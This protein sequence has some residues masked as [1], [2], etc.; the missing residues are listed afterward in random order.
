MT[1]Q[2]VSHYRVLEKLGEGAMGVVYKAEDT[3]L[4][5]TVA[6]K[7][8]S[9]RAMAD[10][11]LSAR[12]L[13]EA[14]AAA[15][16]DHPNICRVYG[17]ETDADHQYLVMAYIEGDSLERRLAGSGAEHQLARRDPDRA[18]DHS[19]HGAADLLPRQLGLSRARFSRNVRDRPGDRELA[20]PGL[21]GVAQL[22]RAAADR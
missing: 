9:R 16:L 10:E 11:S 5:R 2:T 17:M 1:G 19:G 8:L 7:F 13:R 12:F 6:L 15:S 18:G 22:D 21:L 14:Q 3:L 20:H 4:L